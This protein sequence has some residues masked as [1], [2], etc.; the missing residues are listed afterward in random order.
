MGVPTNNNLDYLPYTRINS[1]RSNSWTGSYSSSSNN[2]RPS[3]PTGEKDRLYLLPDLA[4][5]FPLSTLPSL[6]R[7]RLFTL[8]H[9]TS[10]AFAL[11][12]IYTLIGFN[13]GRF[14]R[15]PVYSAY[16]IAQTGYSR[17]LAAPVAVPSPDDE[18]RSNSLENQ[19]SS[20][21]FDYDDDRIRRPSTTTLQMWTFPGQSDPDFGT[22]SAAPFT[23]SSNQHLLILSPIRNAHS[24]LPTYFRHLENLQH[25]KENTSI[26][27]LLSDEEDET[28]VLVQ[29]WCDEQT[30][31]GEYR[32][33]TLLR[34]D[35]GLMV[36]QGQARHKNWIQAQ[37][38]G[39]MARARTLL[40]MSTINPTVD[41]VFWLDA[42]VAEMPTTIITDLMQ[43][44]LVDSNSSA[45]LTSS[46]TEGKI[47]A[48]IV[49]PNVM[50]R[51]LG[52][53][54][55]YDLSMYSVLARPP[56]S[57]TADHLLLCT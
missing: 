29:H 35:F 30:A 15:T 42:D 21:P 51:H 31:K 3:S 56:L 50:K 13:N 14:M 24:I 5:H 28:G 47:L 10:L 6:W 48:D 44:G 52:T 32:H 8:F 9:I 34:K 36:P 1:S 22:P 53:F 27:F 16:D 18:T 45:S 54:R 46:P 23:E 17:Q 49:I 20:P 39:L 4:A 26:G 11:I 7:K 2:D 25:P 12:G 19:D 37:R 55:G 57:H 33:I 43:Y 38:R 40:L 41:W